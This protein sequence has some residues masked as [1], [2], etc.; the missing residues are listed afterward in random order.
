MCFLLVVP[1]VTAAFGDVGERVRMP[2][3]RAP[4][5]A[6]WRRDR[7]SKFFT[8]VVKESRLGRGRGEEAAGDTYLLWLLAGMLTKVV[9][10]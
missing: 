7:E 2:V 1:L 9:F 8:R 4:V 3:D 6:D 5:E 10:P